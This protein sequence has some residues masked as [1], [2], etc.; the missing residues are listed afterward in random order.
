M[1]RK[2]F[3]FI[4]PTG[5]MDKDMAQSFTRLGVDL[6]REV[7]RISKTDEGHSVELFSTDNITRI[8]DEFKPEMIFSFNGFGLDNEGSLANEYAKRGI[9]FVTWFVDKPAKVNI[10]ARYSIPNSYIFLFDRSH[11][12]LFKDLGFNNVFYLPLATN[13][14]RFRPLND[15]PKEKNICFIGDSDYKTIKY[16]AANIDNMLGDS[17]DIFFEAVETAINKQGGSVGLS[18]HDILKEVM[19]SYSI[20]F[21]AFPHIMKDML[22][23][24]VEREASMRLR[25]EIISRLNESF[26][27]VVHGDK[28]WRKIVGNG[29]R[30]KANYFN[31][32]VVKVYN[33]HAIHLNISKFQL[34][35]AINQRPYDVSACGGFLLTDERKDLRNLFTHE[36]ILSYKDMEDLIYKAAY[37]LNNDAERKEM[38]KRAR[39]R[40]L[41]CHTYAH[42]VDEI[43][44]TVIS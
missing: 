14:D 15:I 31:D 26:D 43:L 19:I 9:P 38:A 21:E 18:T 41:A 10:G 42:R 35:Q 25:F 17:S 8:L 34:T 40:V 28:I 22:Q 7:L 30:G 5:L 13:P 11:M 6:H 12:A 16:L 23:A 44:R 32:N 27:L 37:F 29:W 33:T 36:E 3:M 4:N 2:V 1:G 39:S 20:D 24:F